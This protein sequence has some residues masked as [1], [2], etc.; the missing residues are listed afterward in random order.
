MVG[1]FRPFMLE[2][3][4]PNIVGMWTKVD[5]DVFLCICYKRQWPQQTGWFCCVV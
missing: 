5:V 4:L 2:G 3:V 1:Y